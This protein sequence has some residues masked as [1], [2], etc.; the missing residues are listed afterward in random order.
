MT[1]KDLNDFTKKHMAITPIENLN[2]TAIAVLTINNNAYKA[3]Q[4]CAVFDNNTNDF[5]QTI[6]DNLNQDTYTKLHLLCWYDSLNNRAYLITDNIS[7]NLD[8]KEL[9]DCTVF[10]KSCDIAS[11]EFVAM[12]KSTWYQYLYQ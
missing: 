7:G 5:E 10:V 12:H 3:Q 4:V 11:C 1:I 8:D 6:I 2:N 9:Y